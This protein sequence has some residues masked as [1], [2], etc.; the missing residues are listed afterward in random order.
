MTQPS[1]FGR[2][3]STSIRDKQGIARS[4]IMYYGNPLKLRRMRK[5]Y[6]QF[7]HSGDLC[8]DIGAHVGNRTFVW[9]GLG[10]HVVAVEPQP[11]CS[12][13]LQRWYGNRPDVTLVKEAVGAAV[14]QQTLWI[15]HRTPTVTTL[16]QP[17]MQEVQQSGSFAAVRWEEGL[18]VPV[19]TLDL[20]I[21]KYG[22]PVFCKIDVEGYELEVLRGLTRPIRTVSFEHIPATREMALGCIRR[23]DTYSTAIG[24]DEQILLA[25]RRLEGKHQGAVEEV[26]EV[27]CLYNASLLESRA[28]DFH[29]SS[30]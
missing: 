27:G 28:I 21:E 22:L 12:A 17:W 15:S 8:F 11:A 23:Q 1:A 14:S 4:L 24:D 29:R 30:Q 9:L 10:A 16:S 7:I 20:L 5:F 6:A 18:S 2:R 13:I 3:V 26:I 25:Q 19:T